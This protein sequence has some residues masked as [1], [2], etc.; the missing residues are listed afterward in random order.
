MSDK[1]PAGAM[2]TEAALRELVGRLSDDLKRAYEVINRHGLMGEVFPSGESVAPPLEPIEG[3][4]FNS[5]DE[6]LSDEDKKKIRNYGEA[7]RIARA[8]AEGTLP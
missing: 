1:R 5:I 8:H 4:E 6:I 3:L 7:C 2:T